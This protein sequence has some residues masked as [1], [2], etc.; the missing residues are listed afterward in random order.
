MAV[1]FGVGALGGSSGQALLDA[2]TRLAAVLLL[3]LVARA[4]LAMGHRLLVSSRHDSIRADIAATGGL[5][6]RLSV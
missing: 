1:A 5:G 2:G 3:M 4:S 6:Q